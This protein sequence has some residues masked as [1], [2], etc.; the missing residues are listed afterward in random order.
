MQQYQRGCGVYED[1]FI[2]IPRLF[3]MRRVSL[4]HC[5]ILPLSVMQRYQCIVIGKTRGALTI[6][7]ADQKSICIFSALSR[8]T[9]CQ[10]FPVLVDPK[11]ISFAL[12]R[13]ERAER[14]RK[15]YER[16][17][18]LPAPFR[19]PPVHTLLQHLFMSGIVT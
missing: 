18:F 15:R 14:I 6:A 3:T 1:E 13:M 12:Q 17:R 7:I 11:Q 9:C 5:S 19:F 4:Q 2:P 16:A 10:L 8:L